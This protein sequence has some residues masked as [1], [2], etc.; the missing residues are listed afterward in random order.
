MAWIF[1]PS[2]FGSAE[3]LDNFVGHWF[4][5]ALNA[6]CHPRTTQVILHMGDL[7]YSDDYLTNGGL[8]PWLK[9]ESTPLPTPPQSFQPRWCAERESR[10]EGVSFR[11]GLLCAFLRARMPRLYRARRLGILAFRML[12]VRQRA[13]IPPQH[14]L[15]RDKWARLVSPLF[16]RIPFLATP[17]NHEIEVQPDGRKFVSY[18]VRQALC[19]CLC[20]RG[21]TSKSRCGFVALPML[22]QPALAPPPFFPRLRPGSPRITGSLAARR[23]CGI[24]WMWG[25]CT[26]CFS[27]RMPTTARGQ[28]RCDSFG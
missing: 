17:G 2:S 19:G 15:C 11:N 9:N 12:H 6:C 23:H 5:P 8:F 26:S 16:A 25:L 18:T 3:P 14:R 7:S 24:P 20:W 10:F 4:Q 28:S 22:S 27:P 21:C 1:A 13:K